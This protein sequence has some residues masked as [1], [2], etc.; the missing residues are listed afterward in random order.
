MISRPVAAIALLAGV[1]ALAIGAVDIAAAQ[2]NP[3]GA[4]GPRLPRQEAT[5]IAGWLLMQQAEFH[6]ALTLG[7]RKVAS[8]P[9]ALIGLMGLAFSY[10]VL[11]AVGPGHGKAVIA[12]YLVANETA[13]KRGIAL[14]FGAAA[15]QA[16]IALAVVAIVA[17]A[18]GGTARQMDATVLYVEKIGFSIILGMGLWVLW[19]KGRLLLPRPALASAAGGA[20]ICA[21]G[22]DCGHDHGLDARQIVKASPRELA[23]TAIGAGIRPCAGAIILLVL[24]LSQGLFWAGA[25]SV[26]AMA[27]GTA[28]GTSLFAVLAVKAK[29]LALRL[30]SGRGGLL[31]HATLVVEMLAGLVLALLGAALLFGAMQGGV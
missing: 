28:I 15:V 27:I 5:G 1:L 3:F 24:A 26:T 18:L 2:G 29:V 9:A 10:G 11:H 4:P 20:A 7:M 19:R 12:S 23:L 17:A 13:M 30:A 22:P 25:L 14:A 6:R 8:E 21:D 16:L 31:R